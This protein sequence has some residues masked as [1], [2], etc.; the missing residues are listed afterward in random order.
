MKRILIIGIPGAGKS[1]LARRLGDILNLPVIHLDQHFWKP[2]W[3]ETEKTVWRGMV[4]Q[5]VSGKSWIIDGNYDSSHD[6]RFPRADTIIYFDFPTRLC[7]WRITWRILGSHGQIRPDMA[8]GCPERFDF[9]FF[10]WVWRF[11]KDVR[12]KIPGNIDRYFKGDT[13]VILKNARD[14]SDFLAGISG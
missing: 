6:I 11:R 12:P 2:G 5:L 9:E 10:K 13:L 1:V 4:Q 14:V 7:L 8:D 3:V